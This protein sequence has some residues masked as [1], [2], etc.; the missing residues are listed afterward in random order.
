M[1]PGAIDGHV[2]FRHFGEAHKEDWKY[3]VQAAL[4]GGVT[5]VLDM[6][7]HPGEYAVTTAQAYA[8]KKYALGPQPLDYRLWFMATSG[9]IRDFL[10]VKNDPRLAGIKLCMETTTGG[11]IVEHK[12]DQYE[13]CAVAADTNTLISAHVGNEV[14]IRHNRQRFLRPTTA[15]HCLIRDTAVEVSGGRQFLELLEKTGA[16]G[17]IKHVSTPELIHETIA[18]RGRG[19]NVSLELCPH[20]WVF[21]DEQLRR[22]DGAFFKMNPPLRTVDQVAQLPRYLSDGTIDTIATDHA[23]HTREEKGRES[24]DDIPSGVTGV[25]EMVSLGLTLVKQGIISLERFIDLTARHP[26]RLYGLTHKGSIEAGYDAD[27]MLVDLDEPST[28]RAEDVQSKCG[29]TPYQGMTV[30]G[31]PKLVIARGKVVLNHL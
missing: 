1:L 6:G 24:Y 19:V 2:H 3:A 27:I 30:Y 29:W 28:I 21:T 5:T 23:P 20:H 8:R 9:R 15:D 11:L 18:A 7:N 10:L 4:A 31:K 26:A 25:Q 13:W 12:A 16:R 22:E 14:M 17:E